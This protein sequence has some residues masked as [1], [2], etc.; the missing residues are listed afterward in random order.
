MFKCSY[1]LQTII[2]LYVPNKLGLCSLLH[3]L[4]NIPTNVQSEQPA[5]SPQLRY[6]LLL[7]KP[8]LFCELNTTATT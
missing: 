3:V 4:A 8:P 5:S 7:L 1:H 6:A 2:S